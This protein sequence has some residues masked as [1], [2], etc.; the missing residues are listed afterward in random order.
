M[1]NKL[2]KLG[3]KQD[4]ILI[5]KSFV[6]EKNQLDAINIFKKLQISK[7][8]SD[9]KSENNTLI[10][11]GNK[12]YDV[13]IEVV[14]DE[15]FHYCTCPNRLHANACS[16]AGAILLYKMLKNERN[17]F[18]SKS[19]TILKKQENV[20]K[21]KFGINYFNKLFP[22]VKETEKKN[23][24]YFNFEN[25]NEN[26]QSLI[27]QRGVLKNDGS[28]S[29]P[30]RFTG[31]DFKFDKLKASKDVKELLSLI[32]SEENYARSHLG[33]GLSKEKF[34]DSSTDLMMPI[35]KD[36]YFNEQ[37][38]ILGAVFAKNKFHILLEAKKNLDNTYSINPYFVVGKRK[39]NLVNMNLSEIGLNSLWVFNN[40]ERCFYE[41]KNA[42][43]INAV[44]NIIRFPR[45]ITLNENELRVFFSKYYQEVL[46]SFE[47]NIAQD[48]KRERKVVIPQP[49]I[50]LERSGNSVKIN[51]RFDY[52]G[53]EINYFSTTADLILVDKENIYDVSRDLEEE[54]RIVDFLRQHNIMPSKKYEEFK[55][56]GDLIDFI[57]L[58]IPSIA[59]LGI[60]VFGEENLFN[61]KI[62]KRKA[63]MVMEVRKSL[64]WFNIKGEIRF[65]KD[66]VKMEKVLEAIF[67]GKRFVDLSSGE[68]GVIPKNWINELRSYKGLFSIGENE[69][70]LSKYHIPVLESL[71]QLSKKADIDIN[72]KSAF[73]KLKG[74]NKIPNKSLPTNLNAKLRD[75]QKAGYDW[76]NFLRD[77]GFNGILADDMGLGKTLQTLSLLQ[78]IKEKNETKKTFLIIVPTSI[79]FNWVNEIKKFTPNLSTYIHQGTSRVKNQ[80]KFLNIL[81]EKD[82]IL[83]TYGIL[84]NDLALF[85]QEEFEYIILDEAHMI[86]NPQGSNAISVFALRAK[87]KL[88]LSGTPIQNN[89][90]E[91][92]SIFNFISPG[93]LG[94]YNSFK[95]SFATPIEIEK[96]KNAANKLTK[97]INP[98]LL[99]RNKNIIANELP[100]KTEIIIKTEFSE[101]EL[102]IYNNWKD[103]YSSEISK[104]IKNKGLNKSRMR[105]LQGLTKL[106]Q[107]SLH[108]KMVDPNYTGSSGKLDFLMMDLEKIISEG[109][110]VLVFSSFVKM[111]D[112]IK[113]NLE[114]KGIK[115]SYLSGKSIN[116]EK[117]VKDFQES[118]SARPFLISIK[119]GGI[120]LNLTSA[121]YVFIVDPWWNPAVEMQAMDRAHRIG[122]TK[123]V[124]VY[125]MIAKDS[126]EEKILDLQKSKKKLVE[127]IITTEREMSKTIDIETIKDIFG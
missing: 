61:F 73:S 54:E 82:I 5:F 64:D 66:K 26:T 126:I 8:R 92:W 27:L 104:S 95:E 19:K 20:E 101:E 98:F 36:I 74:F 80:K 123:P 48:L 1:E 53:R 39:L 76:L 4:L 78:G 117:I 46:E 37:E 43:N 118:K 75:Y 10:R 24:I 90:M 59:K 17:D 111:L 63:G 70:K 56:D 23:I 18:N 127:E 41:Y 124:F 6:N 16:H 28:N 29:A 112:I 57:V 103:Y 116:R 91:L 2:I 120:G 51:L 79:V 109:H 99:R 44:R 108:P 125:K 71:I 86:K 40:N 50:Y 93:Y 85:V 119:A 84:R 42:K 94:T 11:Y 47:F 121:D 65:G 72:T 25:F 60:K 87:N 100:N 52:G 102:E 30:M 77:Y 22:K 107:L 106:R 96:D 81:K 89:L 115:Y 13:S 3:L 88:A 105:I 58:T 12:S 83:T 21:N 110:K 97:L 15:M 33:D 55:L 114:K 62:S 31:K 113:E 9:S 7:E 69:I 32:I 14:N 38:L 34:Y 35:F 49:K 45:E 67:Q 68:K 122:Q